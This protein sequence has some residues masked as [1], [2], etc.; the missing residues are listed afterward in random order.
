[1]VRATDIVTSLVLLC[2]TRT[3]KR[4]VCAAVSCGFRMMLTHLHPHHLF[5]GVHGADAW[6]LS[7][8][9]YDI[10]YPC[11]GGFGEVCFYMWQIR[12]DRALE[13]VA[14]VSNGELQ[15]AESEDNACTVQF[16]YLTEEDVGHHHCRR[17][18]NDLS[19]H[20]ECSTAMAVWVDAFT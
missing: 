7:E 4:I 15:K 11:E 3:G 17:R 6:I 16:S 13:Y 9:P 10:T 20:G 5:A 1:M 12:R 8:R 18:N 19:S 14:I 2:L